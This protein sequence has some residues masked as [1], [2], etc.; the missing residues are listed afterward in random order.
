MVHELAHVLVTRRAAQKWHIW[1]TPCGIVPNTGEDT[2]PH[3]PIFQWAYDCL[4][5]R[6]GKVDDLIA[7]KCRN[8][9]YNYQH[10]EYTNQLMEVLREQTGTHQRSEV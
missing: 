3:G 10:P 5:K 2:S 6:V 8:D 7:E 9:L 4:I 1:N